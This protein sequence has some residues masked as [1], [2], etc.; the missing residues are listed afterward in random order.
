MRP[1]QQTKPILKQALT[2]VL[3]IMVVYSF[4][5]FCKQNSPNKDDA[6]LKEVERLYARLPIYPDFQE[7]EGTSSS[8]SKD[9]LASIGKSY[10]SKAS[11]DDVKA[12]YVEKLRALGWQSWEERNLTSWGRDLGERELT[13]RNGQY[14]VIIEYSGDKASNP[15]WNYGINVSWNDR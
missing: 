7:V 12:F 14:S 9:L 8:F 3:G 10:K 5:Y 2:I 1:R 13:F 11:Y 15:D 4:A 6:K